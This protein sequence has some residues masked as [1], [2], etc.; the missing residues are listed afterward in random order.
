MNHQPREDQNKRREVALGPWRLT[1]APTGTKE[2]ATATSRG[3]ENKA[4]LAGVGSLLGSGQRGRYRN[5]NKHGDPMMNLDGSTSRGKT[6]STGRRLAPCG[7][8]GVG[9]VGVRDAVA[10]QALGVCEALCFHSQ[11]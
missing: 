7:S 5:S 4:T 3:K 11:H 9:C 8:K 10:E 2:D 6:A 1:G